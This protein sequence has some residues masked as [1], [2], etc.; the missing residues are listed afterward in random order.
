MLARYG[1]RPAVAAA[2]FGLITLAGGGTGAEALAM[3]A[4]SAVV[5]LCLS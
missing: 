2:L 4:V 1:L 5:G 3:A